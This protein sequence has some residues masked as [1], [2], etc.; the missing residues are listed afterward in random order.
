M[1]IAP[2]LFYI[3]T[4]VYIKLKPYVIIKSQQCFK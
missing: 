3:I 2:Y 1:D 4:F